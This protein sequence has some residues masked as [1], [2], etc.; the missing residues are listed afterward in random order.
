MWN[1]KKAKR[2][3]TTQN[4]IKQKNKLEDTQNTLVVA[5]EEA[6]RKW[7]EWVKRVKRYKPS[8]IK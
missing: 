1:L 5:R 3:K 8:I 2:I 7:S 4:K 6:G